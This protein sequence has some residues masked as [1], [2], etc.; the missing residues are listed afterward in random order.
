MM[1]CIGAH[2]TTRRILPMTFFFLA[3]A[4]RALAQG[5]PRPVPMSAR[6]IVEKFVTA[7]GGRDALMSHSSRRLTG[8]FE[9]RGQGIAGSIETLAA[10]GGKLVTRLRSTGLGDMSFGT[11]GATP[12]SIDAALGPRLLAGGEA[13]QLRDGAVFYH[14]LHDAPQFPSMEQAADTTWDGVAV[15]QLLVQTNSG[16]AIRE[17]YDK[18]TGMRIGMISRQSTGER[19]VEVQ[20]TFSKYT[21]FGNVMI[22]AL[23]VERFLGM[24][25]VSTIT[26]VE[27]D[28]VDPQVFALP[29]QITA[30]R[31]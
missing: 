18:A 2:G 19:D 5:E 7:V 6:A 31:R 28:S 17:F 14:E 4:P 24:E 27:Y 26:A 23:T 16:R 30:L 1:S 22:P 11:D 8:T 3:I 10:K 9:M 13:M 29:P 15:A 25:R 21:R 20:T 12:W